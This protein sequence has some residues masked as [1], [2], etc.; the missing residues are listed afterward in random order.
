MEEESTELG[1]SLAEVS[2]CTRMHERAGGGGV[3]ACFCKRAPQP[4]SGRF[5]QKEK[6]FCNHEIEASPLPFSESLEAISFSARR[7]D[8]SPH[9]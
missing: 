4:A 1:V 5:S 2:L 3:P 7:R 8:F 6:C 9:Q